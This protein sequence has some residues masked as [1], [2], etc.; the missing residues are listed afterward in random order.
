MEFSR[1]ES[2]KSLKF[3]GNNVQ[4]RLIFFFF[5]LPVKLVNRKSLLMNNRSTEKRKRRKRRKIDFDGPEETKNPLLTTMSLLLTF[6]LSTD[7]ISFAKFVAGQVSTFNE[8][9]DDTIVR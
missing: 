5:F 4:Q 9:H 8:S 7:R 1:R 6:L 2:W 3:L